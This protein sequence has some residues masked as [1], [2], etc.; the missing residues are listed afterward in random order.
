MQAKSHSPI[1]QPKWHPAHLGTALAGAGD[2]VAATSPRTL[3]RAVPAAGAC[4][5]ADS[6]T[7]IRKL[8]PRGWGTVWREPQAWSS[9]KRCFMHTTVR[10]EAHV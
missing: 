3:S 10:Q 8:L 5:G 7:P 1:T 2:G 6:S 4:L 9:A